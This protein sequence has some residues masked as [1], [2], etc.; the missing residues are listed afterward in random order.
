MKM[1]K[2]PIIDIKNLA[3]G[4]DGKEVF[5][6]VNLNIENGQF[7]GIVGPSGSGKTTLLKAILGVI[8]PI[9]G[10]VYV[11]GK[12]VRGTAPPMIGYVPQVE[13]VDWNFPVTAEQVAM[14]GRYN[15]MGALPWPSRTDRLHVKKIMEELGISHYSDHPIKALSGG[16]QQRVFLARAL[17]SEPEILI[18]DE[19]TESVDLKTQHDILHLLSELNSRGTTILLTTHDLN[20]VAAHLPWAICFNQG[21][22][23]QGNPNDIFTP[24]VLKQTYN[25]EVTIIRSDDF[26]LMSHVSPLTHRRGKGEKKS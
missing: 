13:T 10:E 7:A 3:C 25:A 6:G 11:S 24:E 1:P 22:I 15:R 21:I 9:E 4:Y 16:E 2:E 14:M 18:L 17:V 12:I 20:A 8:R 23:A 5:Y 26:I 19:P